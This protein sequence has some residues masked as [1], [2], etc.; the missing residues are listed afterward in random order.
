MDGNIVEI[1]FRASVDKLK[2]GLDSAKTQISSTA[3][4]IQAS[5]SGASSSVAAS[6]DKVVANLGNITRSVK[7]TSQG[8]GDAVEGMNDFKLLDAILEGNVKSFADLAAAD[9]ALDRLQQA[10]LLTSEEYS[11]AMEA[12]AAITEQ[13]EKEQLKLALATKVVGEETEKAAI[14]SGVATELGVLTGELARGNVRRLE[15][16]LIVLANRSGL[17]A[18]AF[19]VAGAAVL[20]FGAAIGVAAYGIIEGQKEENE[21]NRALI[22]TGNYAGMTSGAVNQLAESMAHGTTTIGDAR[23]AVMKMVQ[24]GKFNE[25]QMHLGA[26][27]AIDF[28]T[29]TGQSMDK[30]IAIMQSF[31]GDTVKALQKVNEEFHFLTLAQLEEVQALV[32]VGDET[33]AANLATKLFA[34]TMAARAPQVVAE[35]GSIERGWEAVKGAISRAKDALLSFGR[36]QSE[37]EKI[38]GIQDNIDEMRKRHATGDDGK[39]DADFQKEIANLETSQ[40]QWQHVIDGKQKAVE[41]EASLQ[42]VQKTGIDAAARYNAEFSYAM[43][44]GNEKLSARKR[45]MQELEATHAADPNAKETKGFQFDSSGKMIA[46][47][48]EYDN[49]VQQI[50]K[51]YAEHAGHAK[52]HHAA[53]AAAHRAEMEAKR[54]EMTDLGIVRDATKAAS[55]ERIKEDALIVAAALKN[56]GK[57]S[58]Q[59]RSAL[60]QQK[61]DKLAHDAEMRQLDEQKITLTRQ[62]ADMEI[63]ADRKVYAAQ[64]KDGEINLEQ[65]VGLEQQ[66]IQRK[67]DADLVYY[68]AKKAMADAAGDTVGAQGAE[69]AMVIAKQTAVDEAT[70]IELDYHE[71]SAQR[72]SN[73]YDTITGAAANSVQQMIFQGATLKDATRSFLGSMLQ[74]YIGFLQQKLVKILTNETI[75]TGA[76]VAGNNA[77]MA[78]DSLAAKKSIALNAGAAIK[79]II[80]NAAEVFT[81][82][83]KAIAGIPY[84]GPFLA[85]VMAVAAGAV[86]VGMVSKVASAERGWERVPQDGMMTELHKDEQVL[87]AEYAEGLRGLV[88]NGQ[89]GGGGGDTHITIHAMD[90]RSVERWARD[91]AA[92][93]TKAVVAHAGNMRN[94]G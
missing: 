66:L 50:D 64:Y 39:S 55:E 17:I 44:K 23:E 18:S 9:A 33:G 28:A 38:R 45:A 75:T 36:A 24:S 10:N 86:V 16:S 90:S 48:K 30:G 77:K 82:V 93:L 8:F 69:N 6:T 87:P 91:N 31:S 22:A 70:S 80:A 40:S 21:L 49:L 19:S 83:Y 5:M 34:D 46:E 42:A 85:P 1:I 52:S 92:V 65:L 20:G 59:Y 2:E 14:K 62:L 3:A 61:A 73:Y 68:E 51:H 57:E 58:E 7:Q 11:T 74:S 76:V 78:S 53:E 25:T 47:G 63:A 67:L 13:L 54:K 29:V 89:G 71:Q 56:Y 84:V 43:D 15:G 41:A 32:K 27:A 26:Q 72:W 12:Q 94:G 60:A 4:E 37:S 79:K 35:T 81:S 88:A